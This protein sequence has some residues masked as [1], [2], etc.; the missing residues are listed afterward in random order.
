MDDKKSRL[1]KL[2]ST[3]RRTRQYTL[4]DNETTLQRISELSPEG[5]AT[6]HRLITK[7][8]KQDLAQRKKRLPGD[9]INL[10]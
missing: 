6:L 10:K 7:L 4:A 5:L 3:K 2:F 8:I 9:N 1:V